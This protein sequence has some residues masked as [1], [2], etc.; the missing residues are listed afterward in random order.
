MRYKIQQNYLNDPLVVPW[1][2]RVREYGWRSIAAVPIWLH[3]QQWV[4]LVVISD[5]V[6]MFSAEVLNLIQQVALL[7]GHRLDERWNAEH[8]LYIS[9]ENDQFLQYQAAAV[10]F[11]Q[12]FLAGTDRY[13]RLFKEGEPTYETM[14]YC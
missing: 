12:E 11:Q 14:M 4:L 9:Q 10:Q 6:G 5:Q 1:R 2:D 7:V 13:D 3:Q 8:L